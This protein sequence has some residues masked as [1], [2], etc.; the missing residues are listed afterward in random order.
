MG[1]NEK[2]VNIY[3][4]VYYEQKNLDQL[5]SNRSHTYLRIAPIQHK[6]KVKRKYALAILYKGIH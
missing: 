2:E 3:L 1:G 4:H 6:R 5:M